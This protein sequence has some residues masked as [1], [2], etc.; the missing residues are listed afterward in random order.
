MTLTLDLQ[1]DGTWS[2]VCDQCGET[3]DTECDERADAIEFIEAAD[4]VHYP[5]DT[6][7]YEFGIGERTK[8][9][10]ER[11]LCEVCQTDQP[12]PVPVTRAVPVV[13]RQSVGIVNDPCDE[14]PKQVI[15]HIGLIGR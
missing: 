4:W 7:A 9:T 3:I 6:I 14:W 13:P 10:Y 12:R 5:P 15:R 8:Q 11:D 1:P 2:A